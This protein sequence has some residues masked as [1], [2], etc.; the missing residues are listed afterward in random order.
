[1][2]KSST[3][4]VYGAFDGGMGFRERHAELRAALEGVRR[5]TDLAALPPNDLATSELAGDLLAAGA[6]RADVSGAGPAVYGL[7][8]REGDAT[9][10]ARRLRTRWRVWITAPAWYG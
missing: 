5:P 8:A 10:A 9:I 4:D 2:Q 7:F 6:F 3:A 1:V